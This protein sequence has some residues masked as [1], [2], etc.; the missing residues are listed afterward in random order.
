MLVTLLVMCIFGPNS[1]AYSIAVCAGS[2]I[3][4]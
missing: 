4:S 2:H 3:F 1:S